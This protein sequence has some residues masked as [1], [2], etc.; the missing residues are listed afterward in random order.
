MGKGIVPGEPL[1]GYG[2][3]RAVISDRESLF[4]AG[5]GKQLVGYF[6]LHQKVD[7]TGAAFDH[8]TGHQVLL[9][10]IPEGNIGD[11]IPDLVVT[12]VKFWQ[13]VLSGRRHRRLFDDWRFRR[14]GG[15]ILYR[16]SQLWL[17]FRHD[18]RRG[19]RHLLALR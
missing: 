6:S 8:V 2:D 14:G 19:C 4:G 11:G 12:L 5:D 13:G 3:L 7:H 16:V 9:A 17:G 18:G 10:G 1:G 15:G